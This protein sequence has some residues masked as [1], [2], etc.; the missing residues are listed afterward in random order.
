MEIQLDRSSYIPLYK[1][2]KHKLYELISQHEDH[3][4]PFFSDDDLVKIF[5]VN[6]LTVRQAVQELVNEGLLYRVRGVGTFVSSPKVQFE[7]A[8]LASF[9][10]QCTRQGHKV[11]T[12][13]RRVEAM[14]PPNFIKETLKL[15]QEQEVL[16]LERLRY[17]DEI[18]VV[19]DQIY[20][21][22]IVKDSLSKEDYQNLTVSR[23]VFKSMGIK[24][25]Y[26]VT[27]IEAVVADKK[28]AK[29]FNLE[30]GDPLLSRGITMFTAEEE[31]LTYG[32]ALN[33]ADMFKYTLK[34]S[35]KW[36]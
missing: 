29:L 7:P 26:A 16:Y 28:K 25:A 24:L 20:L 19:L 8:Y 14:I 9:T 17:V 4:T 33:R 1:Q 15:P 12:S 13:V 18:P 22:V 10:E 23:M 32:I 31:P 3:N 34:V 2:I 21:P 5:G 27:D 11:T 30:V 6:R 35:I 36:T